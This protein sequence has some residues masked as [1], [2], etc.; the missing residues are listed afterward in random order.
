MK[1]LV[2]DDDPGMTELLCL[3]LKPAT[4]EVYIANTGQDGL[5]LMQAYSPDIIVLD[6]MMPEMDGYEVCQSIRSNS[7]VPILILS[8]LDMPGM[9]SKA[10]DAGADDYLIKPVTSSILIAHLNNLL[11]RANSKT[12]PVAYSNPLL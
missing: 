6:L 12:R 10:L 1:V 2:I 11:R 9:V 3:L 7:K 8:A 5:A 4:S